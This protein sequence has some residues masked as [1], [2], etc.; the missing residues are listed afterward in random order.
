[1]EKNNIEVANKNLG[2]PVL[3]CAIVVVVGLALAVLKVVNSSKK[4]STVSAQLSPA[5]VVVKVLIAGKPVSKA[6][7]ESIFPVADSMKRDVA[8]RSAVEFLRTDGCPDIKFEEVRDLI[9]SG[10]LSVVY[11]G[12]PNKI[13]E[14]LRPDYVAEKGGV[15]E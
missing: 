10:N 14:K 8:I 11:T 5:A 12:D 3:V 7:F 6:T 4:A 2:G 15:P 13:P 9:Q 1:M